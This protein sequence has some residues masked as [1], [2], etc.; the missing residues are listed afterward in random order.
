MDNASGR[1]TRCFS[2]VFPQ[3]SPEAIHAASLETVP[4]WDSVAMVTLVALIED[5][6][7]VSFELDEIELLTSYNAVLNALERKAAA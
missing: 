3:L 6:F 2:A 7:G 5:E 4:T 1:L